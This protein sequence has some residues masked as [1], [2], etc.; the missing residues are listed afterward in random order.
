MPVKR[1]IG[2][3]CDLDEYSCTVRPI[4]INNKGPQAGKEGYLLLTSGEA[5]PIQVAS[6]AMLTPTMEAISAGTWGPSDC[7]FSFRSPHLT[8]E[9]AKQVHVFVQPLE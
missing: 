9:Q 2:N 5:L 7:T 8:E 1:K 4:Q 3:I 6:I